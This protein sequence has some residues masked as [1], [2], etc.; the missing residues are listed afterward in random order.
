M[1]VLPGSFD[2]GGPLPAGAALVHLG[3]VDQQV[4]V[5]GH[6]VEP[7][8][9]EAALRGLSGTLDAVVLAVPIPDGS[10]EL[11][12]A[13]TVADDTADSATGD[14][15]EALRRRLPPYMV[16]AR[17]TP[18]A[19]LTLNAN[20]KVDRTA[21]RRLLGGTATGWPRAVRRCEARTVCQA[22]CAACH[23]RNAV[24]PWQRLLHQ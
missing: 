17:L 6:R 24:R 4:Q 20:G 8:E 9:V 12:A 13:H 18:V 11:A 19:A 21:V 23:G 15:R 2:A 1:T 22:D 16:P 10:V 3:R 5:H 7:G 14:L